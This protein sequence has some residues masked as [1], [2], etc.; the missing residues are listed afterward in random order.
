[1]LTFLQSRE[2][3]EVKNLRILLHGPVGAGKS[4]FINSVLSAVQGKIAGMALTDA[5]TDAS[6]TK[7]VQMTL[8]FSFLS[9]FRE[10]FLA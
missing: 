9:I 5:N 1:M 4:S 8:F 2:F 7:E 6:F 10:R 3:Q